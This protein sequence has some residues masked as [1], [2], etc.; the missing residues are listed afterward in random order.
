VFVDGSCDVFTVLMMG[1][2]SAGRPC[3]LRHVVLYESVGEQNVMS[4]D[5]LL[6]PT[7]CGTCVCS[8]VLFSVNMLLN[9]VASEIS[10]A[11]CELSEYQSVC[12]CA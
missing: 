11:L 12:Y 6:N 9:C 3:T 2:R 10:L 1:K 5:V 8:S 4:C 7:L